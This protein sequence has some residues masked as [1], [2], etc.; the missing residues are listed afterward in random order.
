MAF[1]ARQGRQGAKEAEASFPADLKT[2]Q[3]KPLFA[4]SPKVV[5]A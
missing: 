5:K 3:T 4:K 1:R 2:Q